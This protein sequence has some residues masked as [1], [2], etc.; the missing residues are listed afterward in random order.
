MV[1]RA[2]KDECRGVNSKREG[3]EVCHMGETPE[4]PTCYSQAALPL[5]TFITQTEYA[6]N[7]QRK[8]MLASSSL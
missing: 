7:V 4:K 6:G 1:V 3:E 2:L 5:E 8:D